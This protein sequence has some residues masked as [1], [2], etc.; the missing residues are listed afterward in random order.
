M[1]VVVDANVVMNNPLLRGHKWD[2]AKGAIEA[3]RLRLVLPE[4]ARLEVIGGY[5]RHHEE[6]IRQVTSIVRKSTNRAREA[7]ESLLRVYA[8]EIGE[9]EAVLNGRLRDIGFETPDPSEHSHLQLT[10]RAVDRV[11][12]FNE[13]GGGYRDTLL[14]LTAIEQIDERPFD[15]L[16]LISDDGIFT[17]R[18]QELAAELLR[19]TQAELTVMRSIDNVEF[20]GEYEDG[21]FDGADLDFDMSDIVRKIEAAL[22]GTDISRWSPP[23]LD[24]AEV[25]RVWRV[26]LDLAT[27]EFKKRYGSTIFE[28]SV[29]ATADID[30]EVLIIHDVF[31]DDI[32]YSKS[33]ARWYLDIRWRGEIEND[34]TRFRDEGAIEVVGWAERRGSP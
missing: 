15:S 7:A 12:P 16:V 33:S 34:A 19:L 2:V 21:I 24:H 1:L 11:P 32:D 5:R 22:P 3:G 8:M 31:G 25:Q 10:R 9:Y 4:V 18:R 28:V 30:A 17:K 27:I 23:A 13:T 20:P 29:E 26:N 6:K 14:W